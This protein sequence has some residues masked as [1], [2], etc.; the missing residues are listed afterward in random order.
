M[1]HQCCIFCILCCHGEK[2]G[3][4]VLVIVLV[5]ILVLVLIVLVLLVVFSIPAVFG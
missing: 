1:L 5:V 3:F 2:S 4:R